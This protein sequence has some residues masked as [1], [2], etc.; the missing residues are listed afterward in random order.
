VAAGGGR[1]SG[2]TRTATTATR[3]GRPDVLPERFDPGQ[4][5]TLGMVASEWLAALLAVGP[6]DRDAAEAGVRRAYRAAALAPPERVVWLGSPPAGAVAVAL[7]AGL[8]ADLAVPDPRWERVRDEL[9]RQGQPTVPGRAGCP[10]RPRIGPL[11]WAR[12]RTRLRRRMGPRLWEQAWSATAGALLGR[13]P[14]RIWRLQLVEAP[15]PVDSRLGWPASERLENEAVSG[16]PEVV[17]CALADGLGRVLPGLAGPERLAGLRRVTRAAGWW[18]PLERVAVMTDRPFALH[19]DEQG[20]LHRPDGP[21]LAYTDGSG[22]HAWHGTLVPSELIA[23]LPEL[24][25]D[26]ITAEPNVE[27]RRVMREAYGL[28][29]YLRDAGGSLV[30]KDAYGRLWRLHRPGSE[31]LVMVEVVNAT[32]EPD[33]SHA[34]Y[35]LRVPPDIR[36]AHAAVAWTFGRNEGNYRP[37]VET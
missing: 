35:W 1:L 4:L 32:P 22:L 23:R 21:A 16:I 10:V 31:A 24:R 9:E 37:L 6:T 28:E 27:L 18:W 3:S 13:L 8:D 17:W 11:L 29:R 36:S 14:E 34:T 15:G 20:R 5:A 25:V 33:G 26:D 7:L 12:V 19:R 30:S 2:A